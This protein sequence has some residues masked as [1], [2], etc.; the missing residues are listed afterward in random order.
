LVLKRWVDSIQGG[1][2]RSLDRIFGR[3]RRR[4]G[5]TTLEMLYLAILFIF[6]AGFVNTMLEGVRRNPQGLLI[7]PDRT[8][9]SLAEGFIN[10]MMLAFGTLGFYML[11]QGSRPGGMRRESGFY[12][13]GG[14]TILLMAVIIGLYLLGIKRF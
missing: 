10:L 4:P 11:Y 1:I 3:T 12:L 2:S 6:S 14:F 13:V 7:I 9:Q 5:D 8:V